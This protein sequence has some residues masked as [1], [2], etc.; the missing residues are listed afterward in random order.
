MN[1]KCPVCKNKFD[2]SLSNTRFCSSTCQKKRQETTK[3]YIQKNKDKIKQHYEDNKKSII[4]KT[5]IWKNNNKSK[6]ISHNKK[7]KLKNKYKIKQYYEDNKEVILS[8][9]NSYYESIK[10]DSE[11]KVKKSIRSKLYR[12]NNV[13]KEKLRHINYYKNNKSKINSYKRF[14]RSNNPIV[15]LHDSISRAV[16]IFLND[17][18]LSKNGR[19][20]QNIIGYSFEDLK[21]H[22][23]SQFDEFMTWDNYGSYWHIDHCT[24]KSWFNIKEVGDVEF[25]KCWCLANL[26]PMEA[27]ANMS[28]GNRFEE[29]T[30]VSV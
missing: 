13:E 3:R 16:S 30:E 26:K 2:S 9:Q 6:V 17:N 18:N 22:L 10:D 14:R 11:F 20:I 25:K 4:L 15:R 29:S 23:E 1:N 5:K 21:I 27:K 28:K 8:K 7:Y 12:L 19:H 24:P